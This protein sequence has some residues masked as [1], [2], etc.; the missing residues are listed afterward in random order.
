MSKASNE[1]SRSSERPFVTVNGDASP[2]R[3]ERLLGYS[4]DQRMIYYG[5]RQQFRV[6]YSLSPWEK[7][8]ANRTLEKS[9][10]HIRRGS[11]KLSQYD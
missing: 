9:Q 5:K 2:A 10:S 11:D 1:G 4:D 3:S 8:V 7:E 6:R